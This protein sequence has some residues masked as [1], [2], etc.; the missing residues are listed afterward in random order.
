MKKAEPVRLNVALLVWIYLLTLLGGYFNGGAVLLHERPASHHTG[1]LTGLV[2]AA[3]AA[4]GALLLEILG[5]LL[6][7]AVGATL[8]GVLFH[9]RRLRPS[10]RYGLVLMGM[11]LLLGLAILLKGD[12]KLLLYLGAGFMGLQNGLF[13]FYKSVLVRTTHMTG[14][15]TDFGFALGSFLSGSRHE[16]GKVKY[17][18][19][20]LLAF[21]AGGFLAAGILTFG[22]RVFWCGL[23]GAYFAIGLYYFYLRERKLFG[24]PTA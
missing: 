3:L 8:A 15:L 21:V 7:F 17:Y 11:G 23:A 12:H 10:M 18:G 13:I 6:A 16:L 5:V 19:V 9:D 24:A 4:N 14:T 22:E 20:S 2:P 1:N